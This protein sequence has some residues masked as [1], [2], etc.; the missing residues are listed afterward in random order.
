[1]RALRLRPIAIEMWRREGR[2]GQQTDRERYEWTERLAF[3]LVLADGRVYDGG[4]VGQLGEEPLLRAG[5]A[6]TA[7]APTRGHAASA[8]GVGVVMVVVM[9]N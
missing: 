4:G 8:P 2:V 5:S 1:M 3:Y 7:A 9:G 6:P